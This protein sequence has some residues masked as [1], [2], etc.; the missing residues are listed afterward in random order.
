MGLDEGEKSLY[1]RAQAAIQK[2]E[3]LISVKGNEK[4]VLDSSKE[5]IEILE[6]LKE[7]S[8]TR[9]GIPHGVLDWEVRAR[10]LTSRAYY[11]L[12]RKILAFSEDDRAKKRV[13]Y[14]KSA[15]EGKTCLEIINMLEQRVKYGRLLESRLSFNI[16]NEKANRNNAVGKS[17]RHK[18]KYTDHKGKQ[19]KELKNIL[20]YLDEA[21]KSYREIKK[22]K[23]ET[24]AEVY[25]RSIE[26]G[27]KYD[28]K[29][30]YIEYEIRNIIED[31]AYINLEAGEAI[32]EVSDARVGRDY[33][34]KAA[35]YYKKALKYFKKIRKKDYKTERN[36][37]YINIRIGDSL[38]KGEDWKR[39]V[40]EK[41][42]QRIDEE[43]MKKGHHYFITA[44]KMLNNL[45]K[46]REIREKD[47]LIL[48]WNKAKINSQLGAYWRDTGNVTRALYFKM[49]C[50]TLLKELPAGESLSLFTKEY[51]FL[52]RIIKKL[53]G[54]DQRVVPKTR[55]YLLK[56]RKKLID[57]LKKSSIDKKAKEV[58]LKFFDTILTR[59][60]EAEVT[61]S[62]K[63][64]TYMLMFWAK[65]MDDD[66][67]NDM[68][69]E[70]RILR[71]VFEKNLDLVSRY[72]PKV[73]DILRHLNKIHKVRPDNKYVE[74]RIRDLNQLLEDKVEYKLPGF[75]DIVKP[76]DAEEVKIANKL[77]ALAEDLIDNEVYIP[78]AG[79]AI[80][81]FV[82]KFA[83]PD[84]DVYVSELNEE[85]IVRVRRIAE[86][87]PLLAVIEEKP[88][89]TT[90]IV[91]MNISMIK[92]FKHMSGWRKFLVIRPTKYGQIGKLR[93]RKRAEYPQ[94]MAD[95]SEDSVGTS[96][97][98]RINRWGMLNELE[99][100]V[101]K[102]GYKVAI[103][104][105][106]KL[107]NEEF[108]LRIVK[109]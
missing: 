51:A 101:K 33:F 8:D 47:R 24:E 58:Q 52:K 88:K 7:T 53:K 3:K 99:K 67:L 25:S 17:L 2:T 89:M 4:D 72:E 64:I 38:F 107:E 30:T 48:V 39:R 29:A 105:I 9:K 26:E 49:K 80:L 45:E 95:L 20:K 46:R 36:I 55:I 32:Y 5:A 6:F 44:L 40:T 1:D 81:A 91:S 77:K 102:R 90:G 79:N 65:T 60:A 98:A 37:A 63:A 50:L 10:K 23:K 62:I 78:K 73:K 15:E 75:E 109:K 56:E 27:D 74:A 11:A 68:M 66:D 59:P 21:D 13:F 14:E 94:R 86:T 103:S 108:V 84:A 31:R 92:A 96:K 93:K 42:E 100:H 16:R 22:G 76:K 97:E 43:K 34:D 71:K 82:I 104:Q 106:P 69:N 85:G 12:G 18:N 70:I 28:K 83:K 35:K 19:D 57:L 41:R 54:P 87:Q 61:T